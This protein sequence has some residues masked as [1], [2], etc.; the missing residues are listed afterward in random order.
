MPSFGRTSMLRLNTCDPLLKHLF[1]RVV[2]EYDCKVLKGHRPKAE[3][4]KA[5]WEGKSKLQWPQGNHNKSPSLAVDVAPYPIDWKNTKRFYYFAG[6]VQG[7]ANEL[8]IS[9][10]WGGD[11]DRDFDLDDQRFNDLVHFEIYG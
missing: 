3:Q 11:W 10:R 5:F 6:F 8:H 2:E 7:V 4:N 1:E 9:I